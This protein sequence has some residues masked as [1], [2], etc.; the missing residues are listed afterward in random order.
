M[1]DARRFGV[2][3]PSAYFVNVGRGELVVEEALVRAVRER[4]IAG[5][6]LD[7]FAAE[8]LAVAPRCGSWRAWSSPRT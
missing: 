4:W 1:F 8:P 3:Q 2:M 5:A 7:V 6:A